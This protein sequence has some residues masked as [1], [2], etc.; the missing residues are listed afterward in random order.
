MTAATTTPD[1]APYKSRAALV[2]AIGTVGALAETATSTDE[3][4]HWSERRAQLIARA[5]GLT[6]T[7]AAAADGIQAAKIAEYTDR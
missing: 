2:E 3:Y 4:L 6:D 5:G 7:E 1:I